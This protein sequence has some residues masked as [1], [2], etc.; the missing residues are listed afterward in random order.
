MHFSQ[1]IGYSELENKR[2]ID[3]FVQVTCCPKTMPM[4]HI[5]K[6]LCSIFKTKRSTKLKTGQQIYVEKWLLPNKGKNLKLLILVFL[7]SRENQELMPL[8]INSFLPYIVK[9]KI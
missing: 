8:S 5:V 7:T 3:I 9:V 4:S 6:K 1:H 2:Q